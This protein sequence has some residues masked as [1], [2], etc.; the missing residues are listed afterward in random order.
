[1][2]CA[3]PFSTDSNKALG[4]LFP[5]KPLS[6]ILIDQFEVVT[7][8]VPEIKNVQNM[9]HDVAVDIGVRKNYAVLIT[10]SNL[11]AYLEILKWNGGKKF[12]AVVEG[13]FTWTQE[14]L[15][16]VVDTYQRKGFIISLP[17]QPHHPQWQR[18]GRQ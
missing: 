17:S 7:N 2:E 10:T 12:A 14:E 8:K 15:Q 4:N 13:G 16:M 5:R 1:M 6:V 11:E 18:C 3:N 9:M